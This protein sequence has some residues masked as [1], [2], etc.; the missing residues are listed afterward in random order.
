MTQQHFTNKLAALMLT[1]AALGSAACDKD[2]DKKP[3]GPLL[4]LQDMAGTYAGTFDFEPAPSSLNQDP[5]PETGIPVDFEISESGVIHFAEF[6]AAPLVRALL[7]ESADALIA[8]LG[9]I[10]YDPA[11][12]NPKADS[13]E[14]SA[15]LSTPVLRI[16]IGEMLVV[17]LTVE[18]PERLSY[19]ESGEIAFTLKTVQCQ[20]GEGETAG[21]PFELVNVLKFSAQKQAQ[22]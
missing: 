2:D 20:L 11:A 9:S 5:Q 4:T 15:A 21:E 12:E 22:Q 17:L 1:I 7:G 16:Q 3:E 10:E 8:M 14:L 13:K 6:P 18:A 19:K